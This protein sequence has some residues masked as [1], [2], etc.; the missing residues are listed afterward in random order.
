MHIQLAVDSPGV[1]AN[2]VG[3]EEEVPADLAGRQVG[4]Q[5]AK[6]GGSAS[7]GTSSISPLRARLLACSISRSTSTTSM[8]DITSQIEEARHPTLRRAPQSA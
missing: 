5:Q 7:V 4:G 6:H 3:R 1:R 2:G 8:I